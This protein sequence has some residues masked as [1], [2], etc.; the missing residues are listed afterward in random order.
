MKLTTLTLAAVMAATSA[1]A[2][3]VMLFDTYLYVGEDGEYTDQSA[4]SFTKWP[5]EQSC[6]SLFKEI[7]EISEDDVTQILFDHLGTASWL[8]TRENGDTIMSSCMEIDR[9]ENYGFQPKANQ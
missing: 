6:R 1:S 3:G 2:D 9:I 5:E 7:Q 4:G 8:R